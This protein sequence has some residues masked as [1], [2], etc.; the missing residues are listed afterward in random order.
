MVLSCFLNYLSNLLEKYLLYISYL[1]CMLRT[2]LLYDIILHHF[3]FNYF[4]KHFMHCICYCSNVC[5][6]NLNLY[7]FERRNR[8]NQT[9]KQ[10]RGSTSF[11]SRLRSKKARHRRRFSGDGGDG[12]G[13]GV[14]HQK[15]NLRL[16]F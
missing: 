8:I 4:C 2:C 11:L 3:L 7:L 9:N 1:I 10:I 14:K 16:S 6:L 5:T 15:L 13:D 12:G